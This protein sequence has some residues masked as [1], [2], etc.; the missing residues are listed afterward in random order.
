[1]LML[2]LARWFDAQAQVPLANEA[3]VWRDA[4]SVIRSGDT[5]SDEPDVYSDSDS[6]DGGD[7][8]DDT[9]SDDE[10]SSHS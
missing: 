7:G 6:G 4:D 10:S 5:S 1:M 9:C 8:S 2:S 3:F